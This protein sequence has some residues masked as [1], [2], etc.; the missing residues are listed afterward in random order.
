MVGEMSELQVQPIELVRA[1]GRRTIGGVAGRVDVS[2]GGLK[3]HFRV[4]IQN[5]RLTLN[6]S[7]QGVRS[8]IGEGD[9]VSRW[10][11]LSVDMSRTTEPQNIVENC[12]CSSQGCPLATRY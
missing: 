11:T 6:G 4:L 12:R 10:N 7:G 1:Q 5:G 8:S 2:H 3:P 9:L